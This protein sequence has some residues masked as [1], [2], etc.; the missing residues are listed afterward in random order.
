M[1]LIVPGDAVILVDCRY[2]E[3]AARQC[4]GMQAELIQ[5]MHESLKAQV[6][7]LG[8]RRLGVKMRL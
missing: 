3:R 7:R 8:I 5:V 1:A 6:E 2:I 4:T